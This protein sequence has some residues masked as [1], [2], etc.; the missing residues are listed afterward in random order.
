MKLILIS[1]LFLPFSAFSAEMKCTDASRETW[2]KS[3]E[4]KKKA[5]MMGYKI[6]KFVTTEYCF[7]IQGTD[8]SGK[9]VDLFFNPVDGSLV[10]PK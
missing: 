2:M 4:M 8:S 5:E 3:D 9:K 10:K 7:N 6:K 1:F